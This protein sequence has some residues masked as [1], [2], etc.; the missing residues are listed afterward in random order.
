M[1]FSTLIT[2]GVK[3]RENGK[4]LDNDEAERMKVEAEVSSTSD[5]S[6][7]GEAP[8]SDEVVESSHIWYAC[9]GSNMWKKR[10]MCY[11][12]GGMVRIC[13]SEDSEWVELVFIDCTTNWIA[14]LS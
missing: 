10:F 11:I 1:Y 9:Y 8:V 2:P 14:R 12:E 3:D 13:A 7:T 4:V 6:S 5:L